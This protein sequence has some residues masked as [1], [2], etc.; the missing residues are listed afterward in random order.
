MAAVKKALQSLPCV[1]PESV[2]VDFESKE[3]SFAVKADSKCD[4][5]AVKKAVADTGRGTV[6]E[7]K[8]APK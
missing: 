8:T 3:A 5:D 7:V 2:Q 4:M 6:S 1:E